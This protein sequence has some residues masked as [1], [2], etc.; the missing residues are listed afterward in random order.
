M[1]MLMG[2][3]YVFKMQPPMSLLFM[4]QI[5]YEHGEP[6]WND[7]NRVKLLIH[8]PEVSGNPTSRVIW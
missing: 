7:I 5:I 6:W 8:Q 2:R 3:D 4:P 1:I